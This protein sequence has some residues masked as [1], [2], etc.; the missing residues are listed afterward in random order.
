[1]DDIKG[2]EKGKTRFMMGL[3]VGFCVLVG[4]LI[5]V[6]WGFWKK[7]TDAKEKENLALKS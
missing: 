6:V 2:K 3:S 7:R 1:M 4:G 5:L